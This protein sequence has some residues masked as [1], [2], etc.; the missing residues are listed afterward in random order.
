MV[1]AARYRVFNDSYWLLAPFK[2]DDPGVRLSDMPD[3]AMHL[4]FEDGVGQTSGDEFWLYEDVETGLLA[5]WAF[6][7]ES[8][9][10]EPDRNAASVWSWQDWEEFGPIKLA[11]TRIMEA[12]PQNP[13][14]E[15]GRIDFPVIEFL[16]SVDPELFT[17]PTAE[18]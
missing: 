12:S 16:D 7:L 8:F 3:G 15:T 14:F 11:R 4:Q 6:F 10:G 13:Q 17:D 18:L 9:E 1:G 5:R 2:L